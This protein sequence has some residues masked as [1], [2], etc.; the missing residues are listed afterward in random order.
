[1]ETKCIVIGKPT[2]EVKGKPIEFKTVANIDMEGPRFV[3]LGKR[4]KDWRNIEL[5]ARGRGGE[6]DMMFAYND[7]DRADGFLYLGH[8]NDGFVNPNS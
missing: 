2:E 6:Y 8:W 5:I 4:P 3:N 7:A 1:M